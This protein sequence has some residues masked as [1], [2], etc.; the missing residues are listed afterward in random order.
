MAKRDTPS[1]SVE[2]TLTGISRNARLVPVHEA[3]RPHERYSEG[4]GSEP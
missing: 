2:A 4:N 3:V 1:D